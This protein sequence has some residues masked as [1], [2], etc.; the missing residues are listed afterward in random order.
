[1]LEAS[2]I[3]FQKA[4]AAL[5]LAP[6]DTRTAALCPAIRRVGQS[7]LARQAVS[8]PIRF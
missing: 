7:A 5:E 4:A 6:V 3:D 2:R 1:V 8:H